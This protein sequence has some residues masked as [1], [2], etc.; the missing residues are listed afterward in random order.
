M[1]N[2]YQFKPDFSVT[3]LLKL[4]VIVFEP[5]SPRSFAASAGIARNF[6]KVLTS[7][8]QGKLTL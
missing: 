3:I 5:Q 4:F 7:K 8:V 1:C 2:E 6:V